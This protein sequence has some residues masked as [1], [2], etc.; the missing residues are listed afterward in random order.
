MT[1]TLRLAAILLAGFTLAGCQNRAQDLM[2]LRPDA[3]WTYQ[4]DS[5]FQNETVDLVANGSVP[6]GSYQGTKLES[7]WGETRMAWEGNRLYISRLGGTQY[8]PPMPLLA[9]LR[10]EDSLEW[11]GKVTVA[12]I[13]KTATAT[14]QTKENEARIGSRTLPA[15]ESVVLLQVGESEHEILTWF[16]ENYGIAR[17]EHRKDGLLITRLTYLSGP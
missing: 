8:A 16:V 5:E 3:T 2:P 10:P 12:G 9:N 13:T 17:Q 11:S 14:L 4:S 7:G 6:V 15:T 1:Q